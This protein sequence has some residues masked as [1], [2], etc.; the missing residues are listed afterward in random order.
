VGIP[1]QSTRATAALPPAIWAECHLL[2][3]DQI[4]RQLADVDLMTRCGWLVLRS[5]PSGP[6]MMFTT[7]DRLLATCTDCLQEPLW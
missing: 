4:D 1:G 5:T 3:D 2:A 6:R 7:R